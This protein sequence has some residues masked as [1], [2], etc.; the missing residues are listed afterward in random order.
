[1]HRGKLI[2]RRR[3]V[4]G[5]G[6]LAWA[7]AVRA[8][9]QAPSAGRPGS[10]SGD[11]PVRH[12]RE[13]ENAAM[14]DVSADSERICL[15]YTRHPTRSFTWNGEW[16]ENRPV[17]KDEDALRVVEGGSWA[18][19]YATRLPVKPNLGSFFADGGS[20]YIETSSIEPGGAV[21]ERLLIDLRTG[22][23]QERQDH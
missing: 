16:K 7:A 4:A 22:Q 23:V 8:R 17:S 3:L 12:V 20:L 6:A 13:V 2:S 15:Y 21:M 18:S 1:M 10:A 14:V 19:T 5:W 9:D 11:L